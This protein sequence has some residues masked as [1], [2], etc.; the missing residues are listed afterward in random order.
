M[1]C[2]SPVGNP[3]CCV[4][5]DEANRQVRGIGYGMEDYKEAA[6]IRSHSEFNL[7]SISKKYESS[8]HELR[9]ISVAET[10]GKI[11]ARELQTSKA[12]VR[13]G[14]VHKGTKLPVEIHTRR[15]EALLSH[16]TS[17]ESVANATSWLDR[18]KSHMKSEHVPA[19]DEADKEFLSRFIVWKSS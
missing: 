11:G 16:V 4:A 15:L 18:V 10:I 7:C 6:H 17:A 12:H 2:K 14:A 8:P 3:V 19:E 5:M 1:P 9:E 13:S